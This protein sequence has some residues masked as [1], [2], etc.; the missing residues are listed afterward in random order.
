VNVRRLILLPIA[1]L[2]CLPAIGQAQ[3]PTYSATPPTP[4]ALYRDGQTGRYLLGGAW[5]Y[6]AD[7][8]DV[9]MQQR[10]WASSIA[11]WSPVTVPNAYNAGDLS[12]ASM[13]G[14]VGWYR[15]DFTLPG[16]AFGAKVPGRFQRWIVRFE[17]VNYRASVWLNGRLLGTNTGAY[18]PFEFDLSGLRRGVNRLVV[19]VDDR[20][21]GADL[22]PGPSGDWWNFGGLLGEV[23]LRAVD[24]VDVSQVQV[25]PVLPCPTCAATVEE[26]ATVRNLTGVP[27]QVVLKGRYGSVP[28]NFGATTIAPRAS[29]TATTSAVISRPQLWSTQDPHLYRA[30]VTLS[31]P[32]RERLGGYVTYSGIRSITVTSDGELELNGR[33]LDLRGVYIQQQNMQTG[34]ALTVPQMATLIGWAR[35]LGSTVIR[36]HYPFPPEME[37]MADRDGILIWSEIPVNLVSALYFAQPAW[38]AQAYAVLQRNILT[39]ENHPSILLWSIAGEPP[40]PATGSEA[41]YIAAAAALAHRLDPTRPVGMGISG[42]PGVPCQAAYA[43]LNVIGYDDYFGWFDAGGG[44][45]DDRD[46]LGPYL[47][48]LRTCYPSQAL[49]VSEFGFDANRDGPIEE[50]GTYEFQ[51]NTAA[52]HLGVFASK[53]WLAGAIYYTLQDYASSPGKNGGNP[54]ADPPFVQKGLVDLNGNLKPAFAVVSSLY[55]ATTQI[56][57]QRRSAKDH[58]KQRARPRS[59]RPE[60]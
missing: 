55:H 25:T 59:R 39:N 21:S 11:G 2:L 6:R 52:Y 34:A 50:R 3:P 18:L 58:G 44:T 49:M 42:W 37:E 24:A 1:L 9:G 7:P 29:W 13:A 54:W 4:G 16:G 26:Q 56:V 31:D 35:A 15:R 14:S 10:W 12:S 51:S 57:P 8:T 33:Q 43:P 46:A 60:T 20:R 32:K 38:R 23:Y 30:T 5:L 53:P 28:V 48:S 19:R 41:I 17:S 47:D 22:P 40:T 27:Q 36:S 45:T